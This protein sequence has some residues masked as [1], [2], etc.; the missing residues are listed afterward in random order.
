MTRDSDRREYEATRASLAE[1]RREAAYLTG[2]LEAHFEALPQ[3]EAVIAD[4]MAAT[5]CDR[6]RAVAALEAHAADK[7]EALRADT[8]S[9]GPADDAL[10]DPAVKRF[11]EMLT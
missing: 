3:N 5:G 4:V 11:R 7:I 2:K 1:G 6:D 9:S 8:P 10:V